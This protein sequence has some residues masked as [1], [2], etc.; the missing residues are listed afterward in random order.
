MDKDIFNRL[1]IQKQ[2]E[3]IN[4]KLKEGHT[5]LTSIAKIIGI[6]RSTI[7]DRF[8]K[9]GYTF[10]KKVNNYIYNTEVIIV[11]DK[12]LKN[13]C[14]NEHQLQKYDESN[15]PKNIIQVIDQMQKQLDEVYEW[16]S[17]EKN[18][19][20]P[21]ELKINSFEGEPLNRTYKVYTT[22]QQDFKKFCE[23]H[24][25]YK[26]QDIVSQAIVEFMKKYK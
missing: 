9:V 14:N 13:N 19:I 6:G 5:T 1:E 7:S 16:Y 21:I 22:V 24:K 18:V 25:K 23:G 15:Y 26:V 8:R 2:I 17:I 3:Y 4:E 12:E 20:E 10:D 11:N